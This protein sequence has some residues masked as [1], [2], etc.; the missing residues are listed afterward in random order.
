MTQEFK[1]NYCNVFLEL[2]LEGEMRSQ[3]ETSYNTE[4]L[5]VRILSREKHGGK[6]RQN[7]WRTSIH[8]TSI[9]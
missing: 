3:G 6:K 9:Q 4:K 5:E 1:K 7:R 2:V 8:S